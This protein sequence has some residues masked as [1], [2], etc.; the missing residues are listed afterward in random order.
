[1]ATVKTI[2][3]QKKN[4]EFEVDRNGE[5]WFKV[6]AQIQFQPDS[7]NTVAKYVNTLFGDSGYIQIFRFAPKGY[8]YNEENV[9]TI[10]KRIP[11]NIV[12]QNKLIKMADPESKTIKILHN[13]TDPSKIKIPSVSSTLEFFSMPSVRGL[14]GVQK[15]TLLMSSA[16]LVASCAF[17]AYAF[18]CRD[19]PMFA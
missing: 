17:A 11:A 8:I 9:F 10:A 1:M 2:K 6:D 15:L 14:S 3:T 19:I 5:K 12:S 18:R 4:D 13:E 16:A 7:T